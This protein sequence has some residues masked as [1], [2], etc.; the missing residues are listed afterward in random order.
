MSSYALKDCL[1]EKLATRRSNGTYECLRLGLCESKKFSGFR[2]LCEQ[3]LLYKTDPPAGK[4][5]P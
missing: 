2:T 1:A 5:T 4:K 3:G